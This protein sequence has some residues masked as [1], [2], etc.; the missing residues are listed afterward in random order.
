MLCNYVTYMLNKRM[1]KKVPFV[2]N[3]SKCVTEKI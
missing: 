3:N 1:E 2:N